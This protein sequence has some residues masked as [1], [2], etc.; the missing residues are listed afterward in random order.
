[1]TLTQVQQRSGV[2]VVIVHECRTPCTSAILKQFILLLFLLSVVFFLNDTV[3]FMSQLRV[4]YYVAVTYYVLC[5]SYVQPE[6]PVSHC[7]R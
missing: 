3:R 2:L 7:A 1:M 5:R 6:R 4:T